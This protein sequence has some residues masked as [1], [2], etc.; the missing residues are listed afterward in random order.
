[1]LLVYCSIQFAKSLW[2]IQ[3]GHILI[4]L[5]QHVPWWTI[6]SV[7][8]GW[9]NCLFFF[10]HVVLQIWAFGPEFWDGPRL[11][12]STL[13]LWSTE[14]DVFSRLLLAGG[15]FLTTN[16]SPST[17]AEAKYWKFLESK[18]S[19][20]TPNVC[21]STYLA[22]EGNSLANTGRDL[23]EAGLEKPHASA[24]VAHVPIIY[25]WRC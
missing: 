24:P 4:C 21:I 6:A 14:T 3:K 18:L 16:H 13:A 19:S 25:I 23:V 20:K 7:L 22:G 8:N 12:S 5:R 10:F 17:A 2:K 11:V 15:Q 9:L 1:M